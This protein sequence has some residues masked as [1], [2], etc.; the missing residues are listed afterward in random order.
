MTVDQNSHPPCNTGSGD[1]TETLYLGQR[2]T[3]SRSEIGPPDPPRCLTLLVKRGP[4]LAPGFGS[5]VLIDDAGLLMLDQAFAS[6][7]DKHALRM[8][9]GVEP[10]RFT[11]AKIPHGVPLSLTED[12]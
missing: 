5:N 10:L 11:S 4:R 3:L 1:A 2:W 8:K 9:D 6:A 7:F 12:T